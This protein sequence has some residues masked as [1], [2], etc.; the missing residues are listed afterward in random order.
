MRRGGGAVLDR[1]GGASDRMHLMRG[2]VWMAVLFGLSGSCIC[3]L[4]SNISL[5]SRIK[6][7]VESFARDVF[8]NSVIHHLLDVSI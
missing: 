7:L 4:R 6:I 1:G 8:R 5:D 3:L 2:R